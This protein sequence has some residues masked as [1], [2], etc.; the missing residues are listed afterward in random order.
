[1]LVRLRTVNERGVCDFQQVIELPCFDSISGIASSTTIE[2]NL[3]TYPGVE[4]VRESFTAPRLM[5]GNVQYVI[6]LPTCVFNFRM[7]LDWS[8]VDNH[9]FHARQSFMGKHLWC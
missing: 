1:M 8:Y 5:L 6:S 2:F 7:V 3:W 4:L 9:C